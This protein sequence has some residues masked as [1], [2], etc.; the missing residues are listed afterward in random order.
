VDVIDATEITFQ[1][2]GDPDLCQ[3]HLDALVYQADAEHCNLIPCAI[4]ESYQP[5]I[6]EAL[7]FYGVSAYVYTPSALKVT[8]ENGVFTPIDLRTEA[9]TYCTMVKQSLARSN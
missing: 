9:Y 4:G 1:G 7:Q 5:S 6:P 2:S 3:A 8:N